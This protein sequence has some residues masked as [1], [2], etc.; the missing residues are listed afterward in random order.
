MRGVQMIAGRSQVRPKARSRADGFGVPLLY[1]ALSMVLLV[2][3]LLLAISGQ[4]VAIADIEV[5]AL[6]VPLVIFALIVFLIAVGSALHSRRNGVTE[7][8]KPLHFDRG[9]SSADQP[10]V[11]K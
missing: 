1:A 10:E 6:L 4:T 11:R 2:A 8:D 9:L 3:A 7:Q 5:L